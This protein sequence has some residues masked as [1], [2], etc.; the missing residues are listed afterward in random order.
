[1]EAVEIMASKRISQLIL[2]LQQE[3]LKENINPCNGLPEDLFLFSTTLAPVANVDLFIT[4]TKKRVL[5]SWRDDE[6][7]GKGWHIPGGCLRLKE[8]ME[9]RIQKTAIKELDCKVSYNPQ[10][11]LVKELIL[12]NERPWL[13]N[14]LERSHNISILFN[15][16][17]PEDYIIK[18]STEDEHTSGFLKWFNRVPND[19]L[20]AHKDI[21]GE[22]L[23]NWFNK[24]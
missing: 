23:T 13:N 12:K 7:Y 16:K 10:P 4:D 21:Y 3:L 11:L 5:L 2:E 6:H 20:E 14:Q 22:F 8:T 1:M 19:L 9:S 17:L 18:N 24:E 15:C